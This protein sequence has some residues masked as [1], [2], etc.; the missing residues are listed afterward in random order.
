MVCL[1]YDTIN[2][3]KMEK[4]R[5]KKHFTFTFFFLKKAFHFH[6]RGRPV[7]YIFYWPNQKGLIQLEI[8]NQDFE[9]RVQK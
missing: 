2:W 5:K 8:L 9:I 6:L 4:K 3:V 7:E 1:H